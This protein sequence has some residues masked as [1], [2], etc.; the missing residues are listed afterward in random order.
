MLPVGGPGTAGLH[1][2]GPCPR[3]IADIWGQIILCYEAILCLAGGQATSLVSAIMA[4]SC[5]HQ[6]C[7]WSLPNCPPEGV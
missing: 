6:K 5:D 7:L 3:H 4:H 2:R 1:P